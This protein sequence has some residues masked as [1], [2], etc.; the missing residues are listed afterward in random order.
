MSLVLG[1]TKSHFCLSLFNVSWLRYCS[2][3]DSILCGPVFPCA[4]SLDLEP[5]KYMHAMVFAVEEIN[6]NSSL[7]PGVKLGYRI[8]ECC[9]RYPWAL[10]A[11]LSMVAGDTH[12]CNLTAST[13]QSVSYEQPGKIASM[14]H[15][16]RDTKWYDY[17]K[18]I[19]DCVSNCVR[20]QETSLL[21][22]L[23]VNPH[24]Q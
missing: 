14:M 2:Y 23:S 4:L 11:A 3:Y 6:K 15:L 20:H 24:P 17:K 21:L 13:P 19:F 12:S 7:L 1:M 10:K 5:F 22:C 9:G 16:I 8:F 18:I